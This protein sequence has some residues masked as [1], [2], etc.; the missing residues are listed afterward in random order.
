MPILLVAAF[1]ITAIL[2][3]SVGFG[4]GSTYSALLVLNG[5]DYRILPAIALVCN[6]IVASGGVWQ[7]SRTGHLSLRRLG[8]F[9][10]TSIPMAWLGGRI[11]I[12]DTLFVGLLG[13]ALLTSGLHL[14]LDRSVPMNQPAASRPRYLSSGAAGAGIGL[15]S[16]LVGIGGGIFLAPLLYMMK[17]GEPR[18]I[19]AACSLFILANSMSGLTGQ[20]MKLHDTSLLALA[21]PFWPLPL[22]VLIGGQAGS[23]LA[24]KGLKPLTIKRLTAVLILYVSVRLLSR[25]AQMVGL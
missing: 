24:G 19:A 20:V 16:G 23:W 1:L 18:Q 17:W 14:A 4:G 10:V 15:L 8:P 11:P 6:I 12:S 21:A 22:A 3:A 13:A 5:T 25:W 2:Y 7:F 9:L